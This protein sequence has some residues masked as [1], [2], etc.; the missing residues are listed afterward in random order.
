MTE[1]HQVREDAARELSPGRVAEARQAQ[2][3]EAQ[4]AQ[5]APAG[6]RA[7]EETVLGAQATVKGVQ[8]TTPTT[9]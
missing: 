2:V 3:A 9:R 1:V 6:R 8:A 5:V 7:L 4:V